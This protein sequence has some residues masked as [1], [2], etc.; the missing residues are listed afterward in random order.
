MTS[1]NHNSTLDML[2]EE[3]SDDNMEVEDDPLPED[4]QI[5]SH[6]GRSS[7]STKTSSYKPITNGHSQLE[8]SSGSEDFDDE[9][10]VSK[11]AI[12]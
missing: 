11:K 7:S 2:D 12:K 8:D 1:S 9:K 10:V 4:E 5:S 3:G 6:L